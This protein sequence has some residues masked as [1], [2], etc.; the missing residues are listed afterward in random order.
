VFKCCHATDAQCNGTQSR[1]VIQ[2]LTFVASLS[3]IRA[4]HLL[5]S[6]GPSMCLIQ[7][8]RRRRRFDVQTRRL[9]GAVHTVG[10]NGGCDEG[11]NVAGCST[12]RQVGDLEEAAA[13]WVES[14]LGL[15]R[16]RYSCDVSIGAPSVTFIIIPFWYRRSRCRT[17][18]SR[19]ARDRRP[20]CRKIHS[21]AAL[22]RRTHSNHST[23][24]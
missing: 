20:W 18:L 21:R 16:L 19:A 14:K 24:M 10:G 6:H 17:T 4:P 3:S 1:P 12:R 23:T 11:G 8:V 13:V 2:S 5:N 9:A 22:D 7:L 15:S